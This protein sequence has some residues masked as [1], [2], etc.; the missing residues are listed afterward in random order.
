MPNKKKKLLKKELSDYKEQLVKLRGEV[1][2]EIRRISQDVS[3][4]TQAEAAGDI[5]SHSFHIADAA[6]DTYERDYSLNLAGTEMRIVQQIDLALRK[7]ED[8]TYAIC[9]GC[10][11][12]IPKRRLDAIPY[13]RNCLKCQQKVEQSQT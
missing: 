11:K 1:Y 3:T 6:T 2:E 13:V 4:K 12:L 5:S 10:E 7:L 9:E 8:N